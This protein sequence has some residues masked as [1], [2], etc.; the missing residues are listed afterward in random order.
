MNKQLHIREI[1]KRGEATFDKPWRLNIGLM[2]FG[3]VLVWVGFFV[4]DEYIGEIVSAL[5]IFTGF[6][7]TLIVYVTDKTVNKINDISKLTN[8]RSSDFNDQKNQEESE[9]V[10][11]FKTE[12]KVFSERIISQISYSIVIS[13]SLI[14]ITFLTQLKFGWFSKECNDILNQYYHY[15]ISFLFAF[16]A[17]KLIHLIL[18]IISNMQNFFLEELQKSHEDLL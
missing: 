11:S 12:Y 7:F 1:C 3:G 17:G 9:L 6:Y 2:L 10:K 4:S 13:L 5:A 14:F 15:F 18:V 8:Q 16:V